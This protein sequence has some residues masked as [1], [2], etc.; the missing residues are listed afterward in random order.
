MLGRVPFARG[1]PSCLIAHTHKGQGVSF[2]RDQ[3]GWHHRVP[4][5]AEL[6]RALQELGEEDA[7]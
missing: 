7:P 4:T 1:R 2:I 3:V 5:D 6:A